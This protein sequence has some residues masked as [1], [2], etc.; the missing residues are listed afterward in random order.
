MESTYPII[1]SVSVLFEDTI[2][3]YGGLMLRLLALSISCV[4]LIKLP[5]VVCLFV[6]VDMRWLCL[7]CFGKAKNVPGV[8]F[9]RHSCEICSLLLDDM[10]PMM[11]LASSSCVSII[12]YVAL[13][14]C[15]CLLKLGCNH[16]G[17][18]PC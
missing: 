15:C 2:G 4:V 9:T 13:G 10:L 14:M 7:C 5:S 3:L 11:S 6:L 18:L 17:S 16:V 1:C 8:A 12:S